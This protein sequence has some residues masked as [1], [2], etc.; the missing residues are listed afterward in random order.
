MVE[1][2]TPNLDRERIRELEQQLADEHASVVKCS[3]AFLTAKEQLAA[4][5]ARIAEYDR[6]CTVS[7]PACECELREKLRRVRELLDRS[8][9]GPTT[10]LGKIRK[11]LREAD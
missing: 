9:I 8:D 7:A 11:L 1:G 5:N 10:T 2:H 3:N 6:K 4:A